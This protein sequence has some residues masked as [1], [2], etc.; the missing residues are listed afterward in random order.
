MS[1]KVFKTNYKKKYPEN[2]IGQFFSW[3]SQNKWKSIWQY[4]ATSTLKNIT[5]EMFHL[6]FTI[7]HPD[8]TMSKGIV[9]WVRD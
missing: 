8:L 2:L 4:E 1:T 7:L 9:K 3:I 5:R 6:P